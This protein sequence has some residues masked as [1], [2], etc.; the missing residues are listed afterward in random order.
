MKL[1]YSSI[2]NIE[3]IITSSNK[4]KLSS[5][6]LNAHN[7]TIDLH[8]KSTNTNCNNISNTLGFTTL[9]NIHNI[10]PT[11]E[12]NR[13][14]TETDANTNRHTDNNNTNYIVTTRGNNTYTSTTIR[15]SN[16][17]NTSTNS[18]INITENSTTTNIP[19]TNTTTNSGNKSITNTFT[20]TTAN[21]NTTTTS[22]DNYNSELNDNNN[23]NA[24]A[25]T[26]NDSNNNSNIMNDSPNTILATTSTTSPLSPSNH[27]RANSCNCRSG[28]DCP[29]QASFKRF[30]AMYQCTVHNIVNNSYNYY[31]GSIKNFKLLNI[32]RMAIPHH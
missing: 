14:T 9:N 3:S 15:T 5:Y 10:V 26:R 24:D 28:T 29:L 16:N 12:C 2:S 23:G 18:N 30:N 22:Y 8:N 4:H 6:H 17:I 1:S 19:T 13:C 21:T 25:D 27:C 7:P 11:S 20:I 32:K 31:I